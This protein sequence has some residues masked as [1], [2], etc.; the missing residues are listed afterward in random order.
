MSTQKV[1]HHYCKNTANRKWSQSNIHELILVRVDLSA[2]YSTKYNPKRGVKITKP[3]R[4]NSSQWYWTNPPQQQRR[5][6]KKKNKYKTSEAL[7]AT[8][9]IWSEREKEA[10]P[11]GEQLFPMQQLCSHEAH[12]NPQPQQ[13]NAHIPEAFSAPILEQEDVFRHW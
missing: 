11:W 5:W 8:D 12:T 13:R 6:K 1:V 2:D 4:M 9:S 3:T 10:A 7:P